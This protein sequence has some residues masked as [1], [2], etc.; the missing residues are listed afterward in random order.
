MNFLNQ[1]LAYIFTADN[2]AGKAGLGARILEH[3]QYTAVAVG[4]SALIAIPIGMIIGHTGRGA[5]LVVTAV[6]ALRALPTLGVLLLGV[7]LWTIRT[8]KLN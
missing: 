5:F 2:W 4:V 7:L 8:L 3:L 1:A 6:N